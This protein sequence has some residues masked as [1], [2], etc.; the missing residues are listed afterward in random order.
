MIRNY[1]FA[2]ILLSTPVISI[3]IVVGVKSIIVKPQMVTNTKLKSTRKELIKEMQDIK[4]RS[5]SRLD[6]CCGIFRRVDF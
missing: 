4:R 3:P 1:E 5:E 6:H 2:Y